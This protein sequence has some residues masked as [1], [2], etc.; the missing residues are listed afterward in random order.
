MKGT[1]MTVIEFLTAWNEA[2]LAADTAKI[3]EAL[4]EDFTC[5][6]PLG[7]TLSK[8]DWINRHGALHYDKLA[9][10]DISTRHYGDTVIAI[11]TQTQQ[12]TF[13]GNPIP[14]TTR[15]SIV[16]TKGGNDWKIAN[17]HFSFVAGTEGAPPIPGQRP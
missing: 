13:N 10:E 17:I 3:T 11:A 6:G 1:D 9:L 15:A 14:S 7:F 4:A 2:E 5:I 8:Q 16:V 12:A